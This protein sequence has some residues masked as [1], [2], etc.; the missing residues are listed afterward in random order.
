MIRKDN[1][2]SSAVSYESLCSTVWNLVGLP[3]LKLMP[4]E[5]S[6]NLAIRKSWR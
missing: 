4:L 6:I 5:G 1:V 2:H 3:P